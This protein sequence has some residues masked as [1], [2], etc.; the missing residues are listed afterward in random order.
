MGVA[1][2]RTPW[3]NLHH[4][5]A[6][7]DHVDMDE[8]M[9]AYERYNMVMRRLAEK[10]QFPLDATCAV[11]CA[12]SPNSDYW[13]NL[14]STVSV[15]QG[16]KDGRDESEINVS[17]YRHCMLRAITY[18]RGARFDTPDRGPKILNFYH[19]I[20][21]PHSNRWVTIDGHM[22]GVMRDSKG[23]MKELIIRP[24]EYDHYAQLVKEFAFKNYMLPQQMQAILWFVRKRLLNVKFEGGNHDMF[25]DASD[26]WKTARD[27][28]TIKPYPKRKPATAIVGEC[29]CKIEGYRGRSL[30]DIHK[31]GPCKECTAPPQLLL[32]GG[33][34]REVR[35]SKKGR[36]S[37]AR[38][39]KP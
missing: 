12:L 34:C 29:V 13:G 11:F 16:V 19:N 18:A 1:K 3:Q 2:Q 7:A 27:V 17:T 9:V 23:T 5:F 28:D 31:Y 30:E 6:K 37:N 22:V 26:M 10:Y 35:E 21:T 32:E 14:R 20:L 25:G 15:L 39:A 38:S 4:Y 24:S 36:R 33:E 8:G